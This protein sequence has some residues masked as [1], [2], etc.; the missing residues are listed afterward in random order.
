MALISA[1]VQIE[2]DRIKQKAPCIVFKT[3][4]PRNFKIQRAHGQLEKR[5]A[6]VTLKFDIGDDSFTEFFVIMKNLIGTFI[7]LH[8]MRHNCVVFDATNGLILFPEF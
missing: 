8:F 1:I 5:L 3:K 7:G 6:T 4:N 2:M